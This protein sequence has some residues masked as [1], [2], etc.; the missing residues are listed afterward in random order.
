MYIEPCCAERQIGMLMREERGKAVV[1]QTSGDVTLEHWM[2]AVMLM[3]GDRPRLLTLCVPVFT[4][5][6]MR[7]VGKYMRLE[8][9][10]LLR[11]LTAEPLTSEQLQQMAGRIGCDV[12][13]IGEKIRLAADANMH[14]EMLAFSGP[15]GTVVI[16]GRIFDAV[17]PGL[18]MYAGVYGKTTCAGVRA[19]MEAWDANFRAKI[20][21]AAVAQPHTERAT[22]ETAV[23]QQH[24][25]TTKRKRV[26]RK[27]TKKDENKPVEAVAGAPQEEAAAEGS[28]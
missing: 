9:V 10:S 4:E 19:M 20:Y 16:Q 25:E 26:T 15:D 23:I 27:N 24:T 21:E 17:T 12:N 8:W 11:L 14:G 5:S 3:S 18:T 6:M 22:Q 28:V 1:F 2:K 7:V 13:A